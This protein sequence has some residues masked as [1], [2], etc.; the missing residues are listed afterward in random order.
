MP[1]RHGDLSAKPTSTGLANNVEHLQHFGQDSGKLIELGLQPFRGVRTP[2]SKARKP[3]AP[4]P[5]DPTPAS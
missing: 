5:S 2:A 3:V 1:A 4:A